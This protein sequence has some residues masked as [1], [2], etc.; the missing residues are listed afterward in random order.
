[1]LEMHCSRVLDHNDALSVAPCPTDRSVGAVSSTRARRL[2]IRGL[3]R[4]AA[5]PRYHLFSH[6]VR[7]PNVMDVCWLHEGI[8]L[9]TFTAVEGNFPN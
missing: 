5:L 9:T 1:M 8:S 3:G 2:V 6:P 4:N 7:G